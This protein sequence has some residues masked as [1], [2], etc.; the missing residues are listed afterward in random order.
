MT[1][2]CRALTIPSLFIFEIVQAN[3]KTGISWKTFLFPSDARF[4]L[5]NLGKKSRQNGSDMPA[6]HSSCYS[7]AQKKEKEGAPRNE[8]QRPLFLW[9]RWPTSAIVSHD[10]K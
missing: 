6:T 3:V 9:L 7:S 10:D 5:A 2:R 8:F 1:V 4:I